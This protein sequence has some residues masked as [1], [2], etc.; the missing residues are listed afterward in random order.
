AKPRDEAAEITSYNPRININEPTV[1]PSAPPSEIPLAPAPQTRKPVSRPSEIEGGMGM[2]EK[3]YK[4][5]IQPGREF[6]GAGAT[7]AASLMQ[8]R[9]DDGTIIYFDVNMT[10]SQLTEENIGKTASALS[11]I[12]GRTL[13]YR[14]SAKNTIKTEDTKEK[15]RVHRRSLI[16]Y[17]AS[18]GG[19][20]TP[21]ADYFSD[22]G[23][24]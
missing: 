23:G 10:A 9:S 8:F 2:R 7:Q 3:P 1:T 22:H 4:V 17:E 24:E 13:S 11:D 12:I 15:L 20:K 14:G 18:S 21:I 6:K 5:T 19:K 16:Q